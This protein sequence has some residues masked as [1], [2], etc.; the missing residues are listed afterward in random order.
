MKEWHR[1]VILV[2]LLGVAIGFLIWAQLTTDS[3]FV[4]TLF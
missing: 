1:T 2:V 3:N 4:E